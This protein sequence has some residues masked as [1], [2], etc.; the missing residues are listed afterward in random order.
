MKPTVLLDTTTAPDG[1]LIRLYEHDGEFTLNAGQQQLMSSR[2]NESEKELARLGCARI[3]THRAPVVLIGGLGLGYTL[4]ET[5]DIL[6]PQSR[7]IVAELLPAVIRWNREKIGHLC[8]HPL[9]DKR[10]E[11]QAVDVLSLIRKSARTFDAILLDVD[12]GPEA[13]TTRSNAGL[14]TPAGLRACL[15]AL[16]TKGCLT[17]WSTSKDKRFEQSFRR[18]DAHVRVFPAAASKSSKRFS[19]WIWII[20][21]D[22]HSLPA[23]ESGAGQ[24]A[25]D[26][27]PESPSDCS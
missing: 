20:S 2:Q 18:F 23:E 5:L 13:F 3:A 4:R 21:K 17:I 12:N 16:H 26:Y 15:R 6:P 19:R 9:R 8:D 25:V 24:A 1:S 22:P 10:V 27:K 7:I 11:V 14:Y